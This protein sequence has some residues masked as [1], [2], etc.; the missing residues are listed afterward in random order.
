[1]SGSP[2][3]LM[4]GGFTYNKRL[5][6][7]NNK[8]SDKIRYDDKVDPYIVHDRID[9]GDTVSFCGEMNTLPTAT[10]PLSGFETYTRNKWG[11]F[12]HAKVQLRSIPTQKNA[13]TKVI[14]TTGAVTLQNYVRKKAGIKAA[15]HHVIGAVIVAVHE[16]GAFWTRHLQATS[17][18]DGS[19]YD[20]D[21]YI[22]G[23]KV[24]TGHRVVALTYGDIH[25][26]KLDPVVAKQ[27]WGYDVVSRRVD[28]AHPCLENWLRPEH[29]FIHDLSDFTPRNHHNVKD[30]HF[31]F[32]THQTSTANVEAALLGCAAFISEIS[33]P[34][35]EGDESETV[36]VQSNHDNAL[37]TWLKTADYKV[38]PENAVFFLECELEIHRW[39]QT[40]NQCP[41][42]EL[43]L[44]KAG[45]PENVLFVG[46]DDSFIT[47][48][49]IENAMHGHLGANGAKASPA[50]FTRM[51]S[52]SITGHSHS[53]SITDGNVTVGVSG[54]LDMGYNKGL[55]SWLHCH[56]ITQPNGKRQ[57]LV[58]SHGRFSEVV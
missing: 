36:I 1:M 27:S 35:Y 11:V 41:I 20:L 26:E 17:A 5:F 50:A 55:S 10:Q 51:G 40:G 6:E 54:S 12:P 45:I 23:G 8:R 48:G 25:H 15:F 28:P 3:E 53:P 56:A 33:K 16:S 44:Q 34:R 46:E 22:T 7:E 43:V 13:L 18:E 52:K 57:L 24:I 2:A 9:I 42:F 21:R 19:F 38:D 58:M 14:Q 30:H 47:C 49:D 32:V 4:V 39:L 31:R 37:M 29:R